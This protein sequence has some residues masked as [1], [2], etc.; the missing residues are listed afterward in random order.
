MAVTSAQLHR[1]FVA[2]SPGMKEVL[3]AVDSLSKETGPEAHRGVLIEG[4]PGSGR[5]LVARYLHLRSS[6]ADLPM[7]SIKAASASAS[8]FTCPLEGEGEAPF[9]NAHEGT[10]L[11]RDVCEMRRRSQRK[12]AKALSPESGWDIR[13]L[14]T[15]DPGLESAVEAGMFHGPLLN[16]LNTHRIVVPPLRER[17]E[18][19]VPL[20]QVFVS[21]LCRD[22]GRKRLGLS[23][24]ASDMLQSYPWPGN[25]AEMKQVARRL[26]ARARGGLIEVEDLDSVL[27]TLARRVPAEE[28]S[29]EDLVRTKL[30][31]LLR[32]IGGYPVHALHEEVMG[33]VEKPLLAAVLEHT[34]NNQLKASEILGLSRNT[35]RRKLVDYGL[36]A[37]RAKVLSA[38]R[39]LNRRGKTGSN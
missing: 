14:V 8:N 34:G 31:E 1:Y 15:T 5:E 33:L 30:N 22:M 35:L 17:S 25:V 20:M 26:V 38:R 18:D 9:L 39:G 12:L 6:R 4:E 21:A 3:A 32:H 19:I 11:V 2:E 27:P 29:F 36:V 13:V 16:M 37:V 28:A 23:K 7:V 10:L 24:R